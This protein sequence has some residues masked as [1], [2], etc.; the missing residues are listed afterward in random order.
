MVMIKINQLAGMNIHYLF[1]SLKEFFAYQQKIGISSVEL[2]GG[3][4]HFFIDAFTYSN[5]Q[6]VKQ[7]AQKHALDII[8]FTPESIIYPYNIAAPETMQWEKS[9]AYFRNAILATAELGCSLMT[10][11]SGYGLM[12]EPIEESWKRSREMLRYLAEIAETE[13]VTIALETLRPEESKIVTK[14]QEAQRMVHDV[15]HPSLKL[16]VD[17]AAMG[18]AGEGLQDW[19]KAFGDDI[20]HLHFVDGTPEGHLAWGDGNFNLHEFLT[21][22]E[23]YDYQGF[24][25]QE[26][27]DSRYL[28]RPYLADKQVFDK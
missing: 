21:I 4:P 16:M 28:K 10:I 2:W 1:Y 3:A 24:L 5:C 14:L 15:A 12:E 6:A 26:I 19:F 11:N 22:L 17:T 18:V 23:K 27:T 7:L 20:V 13:G 9:K 25:G 8:A